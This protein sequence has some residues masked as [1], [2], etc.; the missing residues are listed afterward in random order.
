MQPEL[1]VMSAR[2]VK[3]AVSAIAGDF[4]RTTGHKVT[5]DFA[6]VGTLE[7]RIATGETADIVILS[8][9]AIAQ[10]VLSNRV[11]KDSVRKLGR[12]SIG[13]AV[14]KGGLVPDVSTPEAFRA[15][16]RAA[17]AISV[18]DPSIGGTSAMYLPKL[19][20]RLGMT[21]ELEPKLRRQK[22][23]GGDV[24][25]CVARG[26]AEIG[27]T[28]ISEILPIAGVSVAGPLPAEYGND[29]VYC[30][31]RFVGAGNGEAAAL[32]A[33]FT[34]AGSR[35]AWEAAGFFPRDSS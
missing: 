33:A 4:S 14:R 20:D 21:T 10:L 2:A 32:I 25:E 8:E 12:M 31:A 16:L 22:G 29:T 28:F 23:G 1:K 34:A 26:E 17:R 3:S 11:T 27:I 7:Q 9:Q 5:F 35:P 15:L 19:F 18:S 24:A 6:P 30:G 13:V